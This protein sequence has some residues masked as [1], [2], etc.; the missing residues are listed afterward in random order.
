V[1]RVLAIVLL[2]FAA[3][4]PAVDVIACPD[5][6]SDAAHTAVSWERGERCVPRGGCGICVNACYL[7][8]DAPIA[9]GLDRDAPV[10]VLAATNLPPVDLSSAERPPRLT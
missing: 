5:G 4:L 8:Q 2:T 1:R 6:C 3:L 7:H 10:A 9:I